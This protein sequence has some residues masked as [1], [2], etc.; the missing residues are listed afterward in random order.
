MYMNQIKFHL[1]EQIHQIKDL[2]RIK[3]KSP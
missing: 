2:L 1:E 3:K